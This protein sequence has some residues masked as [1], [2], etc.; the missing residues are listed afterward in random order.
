MPEDPVWIRKDLP[1]DRRLQDTRRIPYAPIE[2]HALIGDRRTAGLIASD[3]TMDWLCLNDYDGPIIL[4]ALLDYA[5]GGYWRLGPAA[6]AQGCQGY[7]PESM[8]LETS[9]TLEEGTLVLQETMLWPETTRAPGL[10]PVRAIVRSLRCTAGKV[11]CRFDLEPR[12]NFLPPAAA[13]TQYSSGFSLEL[14]GLQLRVWANVPLRPDGPCLRAERQLNQGEVLWAVLETGAVEHIWTAE[15]AA[16]AV[17]D[18]QAYWRNW[19]TRF[20]AG[21]HNETELR[22]TAMLLHLLTYAPEGSIVAAPTTSLPERIGGDWNADYRLCWVRD[23]SLALGTLARLGEFEETESYIRWLVRRQSRFGHPLQVLYDIHGGKRPKQRELKE[24]AG[25]RASRPV[26][27]GNHAYKQHQLGSLGFLADCTWLYL[28]GA[29]RWRDEYWRLIRRC[30]DYV[31]Q[32]WTRP[33]NGIWELAQPQQFVHSKVLCWVTLDRAI[34]IAGQVASSFDTAG[35]Q[36][37]R[38]RI[39]GEVMEKGWSETLGAF[40]QHYDG[41]NLDAA[42]LLISVMDFLPGDHPRVLSTIDRIAAEL[43]I[44]GFV[45]R[46]NPSPTPGVKPVPLGEM[47]GAFLP[48]TFWL[49][50]AYA[51]AGRL[52]HATRI[53]DRVERLV[54]RAGLLAE[55]I[56]ARTKTFLGNTPLLLSHVEYVRAKLEIAR[57]RAK[58][59]SLSQAA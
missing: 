7:S 55:A 4:G 24:A 37:E 40:R 28:Q 56:D 59:E 20:P 30:A 41:E 29:G 9:W 44:D 39:H 32:H 19:L 26:R 3:G 31:A 17:E 5:K 18:A 14:G 11:R 12:F 45:Y 57:A 48:C 8:V 50:T 46:F 27:I 35:W 15:K 38:A 53:V 13:F 43:T 6:R 34:R 58:T 52:N 21:G 51:K 16:R 33:D 22:R 1:S 2:N 47:E 42:E 23:S 10:E 54:S 36:A 25:Y 49:A